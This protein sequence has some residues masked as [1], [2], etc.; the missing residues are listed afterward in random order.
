MP[1]IFITILSAI[2]SMFVK[3]TPPRSSVPEE[4]KMGLSEGYRFSNY[5]TYDPDAMQRNASDNYT[6]ED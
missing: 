5:A 1:N 4:I 2:G 6:P 3:R